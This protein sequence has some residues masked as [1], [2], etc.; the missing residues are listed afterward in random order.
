MLLFL[1]QPVNGCGMNP[2]S[3]PPPATISQPTAGTPPTYVPPTG[4]ANAPP[5]YPGPQADPYASVHTYGNPST[6]YGG[7]SKA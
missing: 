3:H 7:F 6:E 5:P 1:A 4:G 2:T